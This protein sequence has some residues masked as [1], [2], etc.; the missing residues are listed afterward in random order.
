MHGNVVAIF[1]HPYPDLNTTGKGEVAA[2]LR[3]Q[4]DIVFQR[5]DRAR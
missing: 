2:E 1:Q 5:A 4:R 3:F